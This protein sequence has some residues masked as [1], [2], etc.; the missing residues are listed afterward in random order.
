LS[1]SELEA[2]IYIFD[3]LSKNEGTIVA[4]K[5]ADRAGITRSVIVNALRKLESANVIESRSSG[6]KGTYIKV[7]NNYLFPE[8]EQ[9]KKSHMK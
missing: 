3:E 4:S 6:M 5:V 8:L 7:V 2:I 9:I 1:Y